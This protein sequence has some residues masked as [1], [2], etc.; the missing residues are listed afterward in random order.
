MKNVLSVQVEVL[1]LVMD[2]HAGYLCIK[3][4]EGWLFCFPVFSWDF[5]LHGHS[6]PTTVL[7]VI[8]Y[9]RSHMV[10]Y[11]F[12]IQYLCFYTQIERA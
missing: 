10:F 9:L 6:H 8:F 11:M 4:G 2:D 7:A 5:K 3:L 12:N 1:Q